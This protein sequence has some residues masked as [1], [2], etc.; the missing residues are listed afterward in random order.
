MVVVA[1]ARHACAVLLLCGGG[2][3]GGRG[4]GGGGGGGVGRIV[5][6]LRA[7][8]RLSGAEASRPV[9]LALGG[10]SADVVAPRASARLAWRVGVGGGAAGR[11]AAAAP[12]PPKLAFREKLERYALGNAAACATSPATPASPASP[13][14]GHRTPQQSGGAQWS[15]L[16]S[17]M[18]PRTRPGAA[19][20]PFGA[21]WLADDAPVDYGGAAPPEAAAPDKRARAAWEEEVAMRPISAALLYATVPRGDAQRGPL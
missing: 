14:A 15:P 10:V 13:A 8:G 7:A 9:L 21:A 6:R 1:T 20:L 18:A 2:G 11:G 17:P 12:P 5:R 3:G 16:V 19:A 4:R